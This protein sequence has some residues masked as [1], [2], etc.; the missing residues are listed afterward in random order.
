MFTACN[1][2]FQFNFLYKPTDFTCYR[3]SDLFNHTNNSFIKLLNASVPQV[4]SSVN[5]MWMPVVG[6]AERGG[7]FIYIGLRGLNGLYAIYT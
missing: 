5:I 1:I 2:L 6:Y 4:V 3:F 7:F